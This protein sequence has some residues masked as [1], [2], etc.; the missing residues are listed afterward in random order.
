M[1]PPAPCSRSRIAAART[2]ACEGAAQVDVNDRVEII[3]GHL[4]D[5]RVAEDA[6]VRDQDVEPACQRHE[7]SLNLGTVLH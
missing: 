7:R 4:P 5:N 2:H 3:I 1:R 6:S